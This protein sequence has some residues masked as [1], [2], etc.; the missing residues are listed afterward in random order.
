LTSLAPALR[1]SGTSSD[2]TDVDDTDGWLSLSEAAVQLE[3]S[4]DAVRRRMRRGDFPKRQVR[5]RHGMAWQVKLTPAEPG[6]SLLPTLVPIVEVQP[7]VQA[8]LEC[9][10]DR[11]RQRD[12]ELVQLREDLARARQPGRSGAAARAGSGAVAGLAGAG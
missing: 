7:T 6:A 1:H 4:L 2:V 9:V 5:T 10:R 3:I 8:L 11:D 12:V